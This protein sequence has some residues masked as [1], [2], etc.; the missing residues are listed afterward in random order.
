MKRPIVLLLALLAA[1]PVGAETATDLLEAYRSQAAAQGA[2][3][4]APSAAAGDRFFHTRHKDWSCASCHTSDPRAEGRH[5]V[6]GKPI[7][8]LAPA[9]NPRR[10]TD[11]A[12]AE[13]WFKRNCNDVVGRECTAS[14][15]ADVL[16]YL[17]SLH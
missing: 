5:A 8:P 14:E 3:A 16:A 10:F 12:K 11:F 2:N 15:K 13:R 7:T 6:T 1:S 9:A 4:P 17:I